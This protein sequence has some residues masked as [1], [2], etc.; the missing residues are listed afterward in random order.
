MSKNK[1]PK[2]YVDKKKN[3]QLNSSTK[4]TDNSKRAKKL[5]NEIFK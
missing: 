5:R 4:Q 1:N 3:L 2:A